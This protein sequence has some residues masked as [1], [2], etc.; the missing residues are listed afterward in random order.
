LLV[1]HDLEFAAALCERMAVLYAGRIV[2][3]GPA[4][5]LLA[6]PQHPYTAGLLRSL[7]PPLGSAGHAPLEP[8][9]GSAPPP[10]ALPSGCRFRDRCPRSEDD[11]AQREPELVEMGGRAVACFHPLGLR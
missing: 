3:Q 6:G 8:V 5:D 4:S 1:S 7:P 11:C 10:W 9:A 2:E